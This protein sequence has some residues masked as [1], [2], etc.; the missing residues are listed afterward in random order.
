MSVSI[1]A[2]MLPT[3]K[4]F[5]A[6][7]EELAKHCGW[8]VYHTYDSRR[9]APGFPDL[10]MCR[11]D[12]CLVVELKS[13]KG[14]ESQEQRKWLA[15]FNRVPHIEVYVWRPGDWDEVEKAL[16]PS[17]EELTGQGTGNRE[18]GTAGGEA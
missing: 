17:R 7:V 2:S 13:V 5:Q 1:P 4:V 3:E 10:V 11:A 9:S 12:R 16:V 14:R 15:A 18:Q 8:L 6:Q